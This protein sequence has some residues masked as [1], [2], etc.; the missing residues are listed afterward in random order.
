MIPGMTP[1]KD[2]SRTRD[3]SRPFSTVPVVW[4]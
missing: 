1:A 4:S 2:Y 3:P